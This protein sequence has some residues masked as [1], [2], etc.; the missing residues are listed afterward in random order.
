MNFGGTNPKKILNFQ[1]DGFGSEARKLAQQQQVRRQA[2]Q[3][4]PRPQQFQPQQ[5]QQSFQQ[6]QQ[7]QFQQ[8]FQQQQQPQFQQKQ[9][10]KQQSNN[11]PSIWPQEGLTSTSTQQQRPHPQQQSWFGLPGEFA[12]PQSQDMEI[13]EWQRGLHNF[14]EQHGMAP[15]EWTQHVDRNQSQFGM[16]VPLAEGEYERAA[17]RRPI[18]EAR[19][20]RAKQFEKD[21]ESYRRLHEGSPMIHR[22]NP[23]LP[24]EQRFAWTSNPSGLNRPL[25][26]NH[27]FK[28]YD[29]MAHHTGITV[30]PFQIL[31]PE[32]ET[33][34]VMWGSAKFPKNKFFYIDARIDAFVMGHGTASQYETQWRG[35]KKKKKR[36]TKQKKK[37]HKRKKTRIKKR[38]RKTRR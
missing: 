26:T 11:M 20:Q 34:D 27:I 13:E 6:Q 8:S 31:N 9:K 1:R 12:S 21:M 17:E 7:P 22:L 3:P 5:F 4:Q 2:Q 25:S 36:K 15:R 35:G 24:N 10:Q 18:Q 23:R 33:P 28:L 16:D 32:V 19:E 29:T 14:Q 30:R 37:H 38:K